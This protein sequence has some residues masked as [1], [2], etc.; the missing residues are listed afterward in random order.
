MRKAIIG[1]A[2]LLA[3]AGC[4]SDIDASQLDNGP[5]LDGRQSYSSP[6]ELLDDLLERGIHCT[7]PKPRHN[8]SRV[9]DVDTSECRIEGED[10]NIEVFASPVDRDMLIEG[11]QATLAI[12]DGPHCDVVGIGSGAWAV[13]SSDDVETCE[14]IAQALGGEVRVVGGG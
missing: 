5:R 2:V 8:P 3:T 1:T 14:L 12:L 10:Y 4:G 11:R 9:V 6:N 7:D 13:G